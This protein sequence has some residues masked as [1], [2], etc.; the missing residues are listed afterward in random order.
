MCKLGHA[1]S[2]YC[3]S[4]L[5]DF[6]SPRIGEAVLSVI[7]LIPFP[8]D[9]SHDPNTILQDSLPPPCPPFPAFADTEF[10]DDQ[11]FPASLGILDPAFPIDTLDI[12]NWLSDVGDPYNLSETAALRI[13]RWN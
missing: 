10:L 7:D 1:F 5:A 2:G 13:H 11:D 6:Y 9:P 12:T 4:F 8:V 3:K